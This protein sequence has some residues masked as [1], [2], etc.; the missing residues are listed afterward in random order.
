MYKKNDVIIKH[1]RNKKIELYKI[2]R[3]NYKYMIYYFILT[4]Y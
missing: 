4:L 2:I 3:F 1:Y